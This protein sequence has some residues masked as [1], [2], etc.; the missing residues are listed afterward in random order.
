MRYMGTLLVLQQFYKSK[1]T[2]KQKIYFQN[3]NVAKMDLRGKIKKT[4]KQNN[5]HYYSQ[6]S[7]FQVRDSSGFVWSHS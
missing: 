4:Q 7:L 5:K 1:N 2:P 3:A 6:S